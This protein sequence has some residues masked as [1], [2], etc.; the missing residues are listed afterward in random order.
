MEDKKLHDEEVMEDEIEVTV[1]EKKHPIRD[2]I[3]NH[4][5]ASMAI[6]FATGTIVGIVASLIIGGNSDGEC[7]EMDTFDDDEVDDDGPI[8]LE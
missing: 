6:G 2:F 5:K 7:E 3:Q 1:V 8:V 4:P